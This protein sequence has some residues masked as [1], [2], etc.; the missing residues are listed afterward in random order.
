NHYARL[1]SAVQFSKISSTPFQGRVIAE[2]NNLYPPCQELYRK[3]LQTPRFA[4][5][6]ARTGPVVL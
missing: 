2:Y 4:A 3:I 5:G 6:L 1:S